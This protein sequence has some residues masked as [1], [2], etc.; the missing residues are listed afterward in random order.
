[1]EA[2]TRTDADMFLIPNFAMAAQSLAFPEKDSAYRSRVVDV[3]RITSCDQR[4]KKAC[5]HG[6]CR[7]HVTWT[8]KLLHDWPAEAAQASHRHDCKLEV[9]RKQILVV[10]HFSA[11]VP[12]CRSCLQ[13]RLLS[14]MIDGYAKTMKTKSIMILA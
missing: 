14:C 5:L 13:C 3:E 11:G 8:E 4:S 10:D 12:G 7:A 2:G 6:S 1:M 9:A